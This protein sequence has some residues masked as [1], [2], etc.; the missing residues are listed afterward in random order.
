MNI[1]QIQQRQGQ[2]EQAAQT[3][4]KVV[5]IETPLTA[6]EPHLLDPEIVLANAYSA[7]GRVFLEEPDLLEAMTAYHRAI[8][9][10]DSLTREHPELSDQ[11]YQLAAD[12]GDLSGLQQ[13]TG[14]SE[15]AL[16]S[17]RRSIEIYERLTQWYPGVVTYQEGLGTTYN[18]LSDLRAP[19]RGNG[20]GTHIRPQGSN[21][22]RTAGCRPSQPHELPARPRQEPH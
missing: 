1:A 21:G 18:M 20:R 3:L 8:E 5:E 22:V 10:L 16:E 11:S 12:L 7:L 4:E 13:K 6:E 15:A 17:L 2:F 19:S 14:L 9:V